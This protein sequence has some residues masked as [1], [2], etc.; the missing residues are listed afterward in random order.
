MWLLLSPICERESMVEVVMTVVVPSCSCER[1]G[2]RRVVVVVIVCKG[3][4]IVVVAI[5]CEGEGRH[6]CRV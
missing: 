3:G 6:R 4:V 2:R 1:A 5:V